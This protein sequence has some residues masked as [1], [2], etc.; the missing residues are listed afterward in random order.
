MWHGD[1]S[2][3]DIIVGA[4]SG[5]DVQGWRRELQGAIPVQSQSDSAQNRP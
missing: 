3:A 4:T 2:E 5:S 1:V